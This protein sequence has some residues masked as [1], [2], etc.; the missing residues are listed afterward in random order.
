M[1]KRKD[2]KI[3]EE[4][5]EYI[6]GDEWKFFKTRILNNCLCYKCENDKGNST[7]VNYQ[8]YINYLN[9]TVFKG[10]C[11]KCNSKIVRSTETGEDAKMYESIQGIKSGSLL[12]S[13]SVLH[14]KRINE[15]VITNGKKISKWVSP[16]LS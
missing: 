12:T 15:V 7:I 13:D 16:Y 6:L 8:I 5:L 11:K 4:E 9:D 1:Y 3:T 10:F 2:F 14:D